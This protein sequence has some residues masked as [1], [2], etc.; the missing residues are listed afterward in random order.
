MS[1]DDGGAGQLQPRGLRPASP[2]SATQLSTSGPMSINLLEYVSTSAP[3]FQV[4]EAAISN[5]RAAGT[6]FCLC[7]SSDESFVGVAEVKRSTA[8]P[9]YKTGRRLTSK[10]GNHGEMLGVRYKMRLQRSRLLSRFGDDRSFPRDRLEDK[11]GSQRRGTLV[12]ASFVSPGL[13]VNDFRLLSAEVR[14][15]QHR[16]SR[17]E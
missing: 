4:S 6:V 10:I 7:P 12:L 3:L 2:H 13:R 9:E 16:A 11:P 1:R 14:I 8:P 15:K 5:W 17:I